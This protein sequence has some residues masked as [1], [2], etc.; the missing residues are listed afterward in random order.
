MPC[1]NK[2]VEA[3]ADF[4]LAHSIAQVPD[5]LLMEPEAHASGVD[6]VLMQPDAKAGLLTC[7]ATLGTGAASINFAN[8]GGLRNADAVSAAVVISLPRMEVI[9]VPTRKVVKRG[10]TWVVVENL[11]WLPACRKVEYRTLRS[12]AIGMRGASVSSL[13]TEAG[14]RVLLRTVKDAAALLPVGSVVAA[15]AWAS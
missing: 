1:E 5:C 2:T 11:D 8:S 7:K 14:A 9:A 3:F 12:R 10:G 15:P 4:G 13:L 6:K